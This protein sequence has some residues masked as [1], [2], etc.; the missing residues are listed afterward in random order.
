MKWILMIFVNLIVFKAIAQECSWNGLGSDIRE[1]ITTYLIQKAHEK[2]DSFLNEKGLVKTSE[3]PMVLEVNT[4]SNGG[5]EVTN[6][7]YHYKFKIQNE[8]EISTDP[9]KINHRHQNY[10]SRMEFN[11]WVERDEQNKPISQVCM[12]YFKILNIPLFNLSSDDLFLGR[13]GLFDYTDVFKYIIPIN[14]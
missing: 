5:R 2:V 10:F 9:K 3:D 12:V 13:F 4:S 14:E 8:N 7:R 6:A 1:E 11:L